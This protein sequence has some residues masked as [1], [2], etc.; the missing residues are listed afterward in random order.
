MNGVSE[1]EIMQQLRDA[2]ELLQA[3]RDFK[4]SELAAQSR[5]RKTYSAELVRAAIALEEARS[6][7]LSLLPHAA[8]LWLTKVALQQSTAWQVATHKAKRFPQDKAV[9]DLCSGI[10]ADTAALLTR[11]PVTSVDINPAMLKRCEWNIETWRRHSDIS[12]AHAWTAAV[13]DVQQTE[14]P[15][16]LLHIDPDRR[17]GRDRPAKRLEHYCPDLSWMQQITMSA[18]SGALKLGPASNFIQKFPDCEIELISLNGE[19]REATVWFGDL[20]GAHSYRATHLPSGES[21]SADPLSAW[22]PLANECGKYIFDPDPAVVRSGLLD[23]VGELHSLHRLDKEDEYLTAD[24]IPSTELVTAYSVEATLPNNLREAKK[25]LSRNA[26][27]DYEVKCRH[28]S[29]EANRIQK[30][31][32][33]G[34]GEKRT[35]VFARIGGRA[36]IVVAKRI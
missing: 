15:G 9:H 16:K 29:V 35:L 6:K 28:L 11:G 32:P 5:L 17:V 25:H 14:L 3:V 18:A 36:R 24:N 34:T 30:K 22:C 21:V 23:R 2:P 26:A 10:G 33:R 20:A 8:E 7:G 27:C 1:I 31:L 19:C 4:G 13:A 12:S